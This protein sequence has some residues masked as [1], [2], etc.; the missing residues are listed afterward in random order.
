MNKLFNTPFEVSLRI[1]LILS[2]V[3]PLTMTIDRIS[4]YDLMSVYGKD[5]GITEENLH[6]ESQF[7][8]SELSAKREQCNGALKS[9]LLDN[10]VFVER[11]QKGFLFGLN[12]RGISFTKSIQ[13][14]YAIKYIETIKKTHQM[15]KKTSDESL[16]SEITNRAICSLNR[17]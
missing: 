7:S 4:A 11:S 6:G 10:F 9:L 13:S 14:E 1:L 3:K 2:A 12:E 17:R 16:L 8:F 5:F 15:F